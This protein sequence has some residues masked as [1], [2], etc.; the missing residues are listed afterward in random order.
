MV[1]KILKKSIHKNCKVD[2]YRKIRIFWVN[3]K[4]FRNKLFDLH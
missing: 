4:I 3:R 1:A 2:N